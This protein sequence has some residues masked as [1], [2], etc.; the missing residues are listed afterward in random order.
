MR[1]NSHPQKISTLSIALWRRHQ[2]HVLRKEFWCQI[3]IPKLS[4]VY[5]KVSFNFYDEFYC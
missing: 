4:S 2:L 1:E 5:F 3:A